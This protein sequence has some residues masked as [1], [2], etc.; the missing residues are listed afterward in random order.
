M[1]ICQDQ[2]VEEALC[3]SLLVG[4][5]GPS[6]VMKLGLEPEELQGERTRAIYRAMLAL[7]EE[8]QDLNVLTVR[9]RA[10]IELSIK[11]LGELMARPESCGDPATYVRILRKNALA[12]QAQALALE[13]AEPGVDPLESFGRL[14]ELAKRRASIDAPVASSQEQF[15]TFVNGIQKGGHRPVPTGFGTLDALLDGGLRPQELVVLGGAPGIGKTAFAQQL[16]ENIAGGSRRQVLYFNLEMSQDQLYARSISRRAAEAG[17]PVSVREVL[18]GTTWPSRQGKAIEKA[19]KGYMDDVAPYICYNPQ[20]GSELNGLM[21]TMTVAAMEA[22]EKK[23]PAPMVVIDYLQLIEGNPREDQPDTVK[24]AVKALKA[25]AIRFDTT[26]L[27]I[28]ANNRES[29]RS[30]LASVDSGRDTSA[31]E[32]SADTMLQLVYTACLDKSLKMTPE[33]ILSQADP[34]ERRKRKSD[35]TLRL[36]K[37]RGGEAGG[38]VRLR[39]DGQKS[40]FSTWG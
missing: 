3:G 17:E 20:K 28:I 22:R 1:E 21:A 8:G 33:D 7:G 38:T 27:A 9:D 6:R 10:G 23:Q 11:Y 16:L 19:C 37:H 26:V 24:R 31:I 4:G 29:N 18:D 32:Y 34:A 36:V 5:Y 2:D 25:Y 14:Q 30:G 15:R 40:L 13:L 12:R 39:F 35:V